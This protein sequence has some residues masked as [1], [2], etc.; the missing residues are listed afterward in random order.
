MSKRP[1]SIDELLK[2]DTTVPTYISRSKRI[3]ETTTEPQQQKLPLPKSQS[4]TISNT[5]ISNTTKFKSQRND[6][7]LNLE[8]K[9]RHHSYEPRTKRNKFQFDWDESEDTSKG[10]DSNY[11][12]ND[13]EDDDEKLKDPLLK[14]RSIGHWTN[15]SL[16]QM[17]NRDW[18]IFNEDYGIII[19]NTN[20][21]KSSIP[22][23]I[24]SWKE[25]KI[26]PKMIEILTESG[27][28]NPTPIQRSSIPVAIEHKDVIG[29]AETGSGKTLAFLIPIFNYLLSIDSNFLKYEKIKNENL[30]LIL[31]PTRELAL[32][33]QKQAEIFC[34]KLNFNI[35]SIIGGHKYQDTID[36]IEKNGC[37]IIVGTP[38]RLIDSIEKKIFE[39]NKCYYIVMDEADR[40]IDMGFEKDLTKIYE[41]LPTNNQ[42]VNSID[43][44]IFGIKNKITM[45]YTAT[46]TPII[47]KLTNTY[48]IDPI[49]ITIG[50]AGE[51]LDSIDQKFELINDSA[52]LE[53][54]KISKLIKIIQSHN[55]KNP[56][57]LIIIF[58]NF[59][60]IVDQI[61]E[62]LNLKNFKTTTIH[63]SKSQELRETSLQQFKNHETPI[64][65]ATDVAARGID[66]P[67]VSLVINYQMPKD[68]QEY[69]HRIGR[70]G[71]AGNFGE[72]FSFIVEI[73]DKEIYLPLKKFLK[74]GDK[75]LP[76]WLY[77]YHQ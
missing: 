59:K 27:F 12:I 74:K 31:A 43:S 68:F 60:D 49:H 70:T 58:A 48:L 35:I 55:Y 66:V 13:E 44:K 15:K 28:Q 32:Q 50:G 4:S 10:F 9:I 30:I 22:N 45:M 14:D 47:T 76:D 65:V 17:T 46:I 38:G 73:D 75:K 77:R 6:T 23:P 1:I 34:K 33:I 64:L 54:I 7:N 63:G 24:R 36:E 56:Q 39:L 2:D 42:L 52:N 26:N 29:I 71:R 16:E 69:I 19:K 41:Y 25:S 61:S 37:D 11:L 3:K 40:M 8:P 21:T 62:E 57:S 67:N 51:A 18:R 53:Q 20:N 5:T 72:S